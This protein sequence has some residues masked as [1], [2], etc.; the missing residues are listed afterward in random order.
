[1]FAVALG[2]ANLLLT[3]DVS[4]KKAR[5]ESMRAFLQVRP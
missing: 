1:M 5:T 4:N 2:R 3:A